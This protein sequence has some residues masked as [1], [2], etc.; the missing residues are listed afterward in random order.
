MLVGLATGGDYNT[1]DS[2]QPYHI[3]PCEHFGNATGLPQCD[4]KW[5]LAMC[6]FSCIPEYTKKTFK[7]D[8]HVS[9]SFYRIQ[10]S[11]RQI[12]LEIMRNG[13]VSAIFQVHEDFLSYKSGIYTKTIGDKIGW[14]T[15]KI[16]GWG[17]DYEG[18]VNTGYWLVAN[19]WNSGW[20]MEGYF[21]ILRGMNH[22]KIEQYVMAGTPYKPM[23][24]PKRVE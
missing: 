13:P 4:N 21:K 23:P 15:V 22:L 19:S 10:N 24:A 12:Q 3:A 17:T 11:E 20:G 16:I 14:H 1:T 9:R 8:H 18:G 7:E 5:H 6:K 2:C